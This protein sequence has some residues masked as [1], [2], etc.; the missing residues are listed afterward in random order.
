[1]ADILKRAKALAAAA[2]EAADA[3]NLAVQEAKTEKTRANT[4]SPNPKSPPRP[5]DSTTSEPK[6]QVV[7]STNVE[8]FAAS[9]KQSVKTC[10]QSDTNFAASQMM[11]NV[12]AVSLCRAAD[13]K[14]STMKQ[15]E[16][17]KL[18]PR[19]NE[20]AKLSPRSD[21]KLSPRPNAE[22]AAQ[23]E[24]KI[25]PRYDASAKMSPRGNHLESYAAEE[26]RTPTYTE[27]AKVQ[28]PDYIPVPP[29]T[30]SP[31]Q[32]TAYTTQET[33]LQEPPKEPMS[34]MDMML[35]DHVDKRSKMVD[36]RKGP[37]QVVCYICCAEFGTSSLAIHQKTCLKKQ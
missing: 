19:I 28:A 5:P 36:R 10:G 1:M 13:E 7:E 25:S 26:K 29:T 24:I 20:S 4:F 17:I 8:R 16:S 27:T 31:V 21:V 14:K 32:S 11:Q 3:A 35:A 22:T 9:K 34:M 12:M 15:S 6:E 2:N 33:P 23:G 18:S 30:V 37:S